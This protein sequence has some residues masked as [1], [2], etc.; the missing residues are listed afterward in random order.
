MFIQICGVFTVANIF[1]AN[2]T[3][4][5]GLVLSGEKAP[6]GV[7][8]PL[9]QHGTSCSVAI[10]GGGGEELWLIEHDITEVREERCLHG[11]SDTL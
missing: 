10:A 11:Q 2:N 7:P 1:S 6:N 9:C 4:C 3:L 8:L 5:C